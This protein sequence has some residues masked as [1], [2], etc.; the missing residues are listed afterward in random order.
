MTQG[1]LGHLFCV[2]VCLWWWDGAGGVGGSGGGAGGGGWGWGVRW[3]FLDIQTQIGPFWSALMTPT[4]PMS[5][6]TN[7][8]N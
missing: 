6:V 7:V 5:P 2:G 4:R 8:P 3:Y 1:S